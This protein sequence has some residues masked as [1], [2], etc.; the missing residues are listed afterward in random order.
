LKYEDA[1]MDGVKEGRK[2]KS[3][4]QGERD[5]GVHLPLPVKLNERGLTIVMIESDSLRAWATRTTTR[6][7]LDHRRQAAQ[8]MMSLRT[9]KTIYHTEL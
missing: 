4:S 1:S 9:A 8:L 6:T 2:P 3:E 7:G 5:E